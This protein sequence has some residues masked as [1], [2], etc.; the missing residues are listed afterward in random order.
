[1]STSIHSNRFY[2]HL[3]I[4]VVAA[5]STVALTEQI[6]GATPV[7]PVWHMEYTADSHPAAFTSPIS[8]L[9]W[10]PIETPGV[11]VDE[12]HGILTINSQPAA[13]AWYELTTTPYNSP[14]TWNVLEASVWL[15][16]YT[17]DTDLDG[18]SL[19]LEDDLFSATLFITPGGIALHGPAPTPSY[20]GADP[21]DGWH[22]YRIYTRDS[23]VFVTV[24]GSLAIAGRGALPS[25]WGSG[26]PHVGF[27]D[28][29]IGAGCVA[30]WDY[31]NYTNFP[32]SGLGCELFPG[33]P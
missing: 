15:R 29:S 32:C 33:V 4:T 6:A 3:A 24:D 20:S 8:G 2:P 31:V 28:T 19:V 16:D 17:E 18:C 21:T 22:V 7:P 1:M 11:S 23:D 14:E 30:D 27:G 13:L 9:S 12:H 26:V 10:I 5:L 25:L